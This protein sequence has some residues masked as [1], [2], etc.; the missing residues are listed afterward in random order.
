MLENL[1]SIRRILYSGMFHRVAI[2]ETDI[3]EERS[4]RIIRL[5]RIGQLGTTLAITSN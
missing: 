2:G 1:S 3:S 5:T 4:A